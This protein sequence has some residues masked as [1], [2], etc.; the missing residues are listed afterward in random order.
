MKDDGVSDPCASCEAAELDELKAALRPLLEHQ[1]SD[2]NRCPFCGAREEYGSL[3][4][5]DT[6]PMKIAI[7]ICGGHMR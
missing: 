6:C 4:H 7:T 1:E 2:M 5:D 3:Y